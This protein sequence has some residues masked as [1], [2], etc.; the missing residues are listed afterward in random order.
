[1][2]ADVYRFFIGYEGS[3]DKIWRLVDVSSNYSLA[4]FGYLI[5]SSFDTLAYHLFMF[6]CDGKNYQVDPDPDFDENSI[7]AS[8]VKLSL[9]KLREEVQFK[10]IYDFG[11]DQTFIIKLM[12]IREMEKGQSTKYPCIIDGA[13]KGFLMMFRLL[14][15]RK[16]SG[17]LIKSASQSITISLHTG[18]KNCGIIGSLIWT[19]Q[20][21]YSNPILLKSKWVLRGKLVFI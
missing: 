19:K 1:M 14:S 6:D 9:L 3:E 12:E 8:L 4:K 18:K 15:L 13:E 16:L 21:E 7:D 20:T 10:M 17:K 5:L 2:K 11:C